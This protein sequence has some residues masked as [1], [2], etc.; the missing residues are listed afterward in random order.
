MSKILV[1]GASGHLGGLVIKHLLE[2]EKVSPSDLVAGS[3]DT[4]KLRELADKGIKTRP[5]DFDDE[6][7]LAE[8]FAGIDRLLIISTDTLDTPGKRVAQHSAAARAAGKAGVGRIAY[9][10]IPKPE[11]SAISFA[12]EHR[13]SERAIAKTGAATTFFRN[14]WY[15]ENLFM[16]LPQAIATGTWHTSADTG[17]ISY[18][19]REDVARA[20]A[21][22]L[23]GEQSGNA[24]YTLT[25]SRPI[26]TAEAAEL[27][28][29]ATGKPVAVDILTDG[30][31]SAA[32]A[33]AGLPGFLIELVVS[34]D[35]ATRNGDLGDV[36]E[37]FAR[38]TGRQPARIEDF[39]EANAAA[40]AG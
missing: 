3:R 32:L 25:G 13:D 16:S 39:F 5:V 9:T 21:A 38:L 2:T 37:D 7:G 30:D 17:G 18:I 35:K 15:M 23:A 19:A 40:L 31:F 26:S 24:V 11:T 12:W 36:T 29:N 33:Q 27:A 6:D 14:G 8:A 22:S 28:S 4:A 34:A 20:I 1:T 10:S